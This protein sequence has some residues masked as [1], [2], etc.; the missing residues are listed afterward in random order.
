MQLTIDNTRPELEILSPQEDEQFTYRSGLSIMMNVSAT[1]N[2]VLHRVE[3]FVDGEAE[4][5]L[6]EPPYVIVWDALLG[7]HTLQVNAY[8]LAGNQEPN[9]DHF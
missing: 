2:L 4:A 7:E 5:T 3:F 9:L 1:D 6:L 8:D